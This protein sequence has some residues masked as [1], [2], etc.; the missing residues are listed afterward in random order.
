MTTDLDVSRALCTQRSVWGLRDSA[1]G[2]LG[3]GTRVEGFCVV[4]VGFVDLIL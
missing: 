4:T 3:S 1:S 2:G